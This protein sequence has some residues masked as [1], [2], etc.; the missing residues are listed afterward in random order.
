MGRIESITGTIRL[1]S[2][3][4]DVISAVAEFMVRL[5]STY[6]GVTEVNP[7]RVSG[8]VWKKRSGSMAACDRVQGQ[9][10]RVT[11]FR[12]NGDRVRAQPCCKMEI[13]IVNHLG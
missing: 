3:Y 10:Q 4:S 11:E 2:T 5:R 12:A 8:R 13:Y 6:S 9:W 1:R 7:L